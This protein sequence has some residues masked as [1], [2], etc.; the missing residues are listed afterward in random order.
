M[1]QKM[2]PQHKIFVRHLRKTRNLAKY[3]LKVSNEYGSALIEHKFV[4]ETKIRPGTTLISEVEFLPLVRL[5]KNGKGK[6]VSD[7]N[8]I[9]EDEEDVAV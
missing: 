3:V 8:L 1:N 2:T 4:V 5:Y 9:N 6:I 7:E